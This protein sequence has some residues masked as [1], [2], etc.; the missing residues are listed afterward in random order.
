MSVLRK[1][2]PLLGLLAA[3]AAPAERWQLQYFHDADDSSLLIADLQFPTPQRGMAVGYFTERGRRKPAGLV[4]KDGGLTW[5]SVPVPRPAVSLFFAGENLGWLVAGD[6]TIWLTTEFGQN[7]KRLS[8]L[9]GVVRVYFRDEHRGWAVG[10]RKSVWE[11]TDGGKRWTSLPAASEPKTTRDFTVYTC[12]AFANPDTG[13]I[14]GWSKPPRGNPRW[15]PVPDWMAPERR[16]REVPSVSL[17]LETRDGGAHWKAS[18]GSLF[19]RVTQVRMAPDGRGLGLIEFLDAFEWPAEVIGFDWRTGKS[20]RVFRRKDRAVTAVALPP[21]GP[22]YL[23]AI[24]PPGALARS[25]VP[26]KLKLLQS[27]NFSDWKEMQVDYRAVARRAILAAP[28]AAHLWVATD[29]GMIL[30]LVRE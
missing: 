22:A 3:A 19:G 25:P 4:T 10:A 8:R 12:I 17:V 11:T 15:P 26:G 27:D 7:W 14:T 16:P 20:V 29:T 18:A 5:T 21:Q 23:A 6:G 1:V 24:E 28:D 30:K 13:M 2:L 9:P